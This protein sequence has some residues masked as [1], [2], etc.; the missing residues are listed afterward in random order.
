MN[1]FACGIALMSL[2]MAG[3]CG[4][5]I[6]LDL[7]DLGVG[8]LYLAGCTLLCFASACQIEDF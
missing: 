4:L 1:Y 6:A 8:G 3:A 5:G 2:L 7:V